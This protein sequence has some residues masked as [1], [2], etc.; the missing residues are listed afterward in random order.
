MSVINP[1]KKHYL[2]IGIK[3]N[4]LNGKN[5]NVQKESGNLSIKDK[6]KGEDVD[7]MSP[8]LIRDMTTPGLFA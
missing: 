4:G 5:K 3:L 7:A 1:V 2:L 6:R 8:S